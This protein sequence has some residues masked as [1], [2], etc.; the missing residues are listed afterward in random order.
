MLL[1]KQNKRS[2]Y[3]AKKY[4]QQKFIGVKNNGNKAL[5]LLAA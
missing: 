3:E 4:F 2:L 5:K 1:E